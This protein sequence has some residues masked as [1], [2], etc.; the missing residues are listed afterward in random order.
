MAAQLTLNLLLLTGS[1]EA[2]YDLSTPFFNREEC[3]DL[4]GGQGKAKVTVVPQGGAFRLHMGFEGQVSLVCDR[5]L[6]AV[7]MPLHCEEDL[8]LKVGQASLEAEDNEEWIDPQTGLC[9]LDWLLF[10][11]IVI[12]LPMTHCHP[13]GECNPRMEALL[14]AHHAESAE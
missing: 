6:D 7:E 11:M 14:Q 12:N 2:E 8:V 4:L 1:Y 5:C 13:N 9:D 3:A 10:E